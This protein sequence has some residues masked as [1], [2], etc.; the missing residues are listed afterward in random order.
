MS[1]PLRIV[2]CCQQDLRPHP[3]PAYRFWAETFRAA[4][5]EA[6]HAC[7]EVPGCDWAEG[8]T[9]LAPAAR[10]GWLESTWRRTVDFI[11]RE[12]ARRP[13][14]LFLSYLYPDQVM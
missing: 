7:L 12:H 13:V 5:A 8:L 10:A 1:T 2:L 6:G 3:L 14:D 4:L 11:R 9:P